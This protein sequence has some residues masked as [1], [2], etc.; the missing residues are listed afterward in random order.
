MNS[1]I[2]LNDL[3]LL[4][5][6]HQILNSINLKVGVGQCYGILGPNGSGKTSL[7]RCMY[8]SLSPSSGSINLF[9]KLLSE[10]G[11]SERAQMIAV[12]LQEM[13]PE[14]ALTVADILKLGRLP[15][16]TLFS[17]SDYSPSGQEFDQYEQKIIHELDLNNFLSRVYKR[18]SGGEK[19]R[20]MLARALFQKPKLLFLDEPTNHL[21]ISH[22]ISLIKYVSC[23]DITVICSLH[24]LNLASRYCDQVAIIDSGHLVDI[25]DPQQVLAKE[26]IEQVYSVKSFRFNNP[27]TG[28]TSLDFY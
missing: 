9:G 20:V 13:N 21:D 3:T 11:R 6:K 1:A 25:G 24:D 27:N 5:D 26:L 15:Y 7:L 8:G 16:Q 23:L 2:T 28:K 4:I 12:V 19:Q 17:S 10:Y 18:L 14:L 22:Q